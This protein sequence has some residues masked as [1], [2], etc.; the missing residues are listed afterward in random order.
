MRYAGRVG[1]GFLNHGNSGSRPKTP[2]IRSN[3]GNGPR[4][5]S[6]GVREYGFS[7]LNLFAA[8]DGTFNL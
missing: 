4:D 3:R 1:S 7:I 2:D 5:V 6:A 8:Q